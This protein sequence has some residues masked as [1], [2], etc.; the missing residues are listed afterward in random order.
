MKLREWLLK[1][2]PEELGL[3]ILAVATFIVAVACAIGITS[4]GIGEAIHRAGITS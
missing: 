3:L 1:Q 4:C 2:D